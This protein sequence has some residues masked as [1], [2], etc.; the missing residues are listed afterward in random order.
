MNT[1]SLDK[2][3][4][5]DVVNAIYSSWHDVIS[6]IPQGSI[7]GPLCLLYTLIIYHT[8]VMI[9]IQN[10]TYTQMILNSL[11]ILVTM[12]INTVCNMA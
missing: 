7:L 8:T 3:H 11:D 12:M 9:C 1:D 4:F 10:F 2:I 6:G 5:R